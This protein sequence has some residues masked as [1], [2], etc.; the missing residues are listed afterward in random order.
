MRIFA[1]TRIIQSALQSW[2]DHPTKSWKIVI[3]RAK[4]PSVMTNPDF[5]LS[6]KGFETNT[7]IISL[8]SKIRWRVEGVRER[9]LERPFFWNSRCP[10]RVLL[11][12]ANLQYHIF[13]VSPREGQEALPFFSASLNEWDPSEWGKWTHAPSFLNGFTHEF[14]SQPFKPPTKSPSLSINCSASAGNS[15]TKRWSQGLLGNNSWKVG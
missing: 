7:P 10:P 11:Q 13:K 14:T 9:K 15:F 8:M 6:G 1:K 4:T 3:H 12:H 2:T 5:L